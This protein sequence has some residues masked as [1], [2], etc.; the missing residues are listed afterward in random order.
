M[1]VSAIERKEYVEIFLIYGITQLDV[2][3]KCLYLDL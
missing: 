1:L 3:L 2:S